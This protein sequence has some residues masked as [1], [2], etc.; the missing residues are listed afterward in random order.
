MFHIF[1]SF[2]N[3]FI[4]H[5]GNH[6]ITVFAALKWNPLSHHINFHTYIMVI[7]NKYNLN[8]PSDIMAQSM[9]TI[10]VYTL[11]GIISLVSSV[12]VYHYVQLIGYGTMGHNYHQISNIS[13]TK[14][15]ILHV[16]HLV[17]Q[18]Y[19]CNLLKPG[20]KFEWR[21]SW[22]STD[23]WCSNYIWVITILLPTK[24]RFILE[25]WW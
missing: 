5:S 13:C 1:Q 21:C 11:C 16:S 24:A 6:M 4:W 7:F 19:L 15:Q 14:S 12:H 22:S 18:L 23:R 3:V 2:F 9:V 17:L 25:A 10:I 8:Y 20:V